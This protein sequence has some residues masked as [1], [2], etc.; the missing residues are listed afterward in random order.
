MRKIARG[1]TNR[2]S[3]VLFTKGRR[4]FPVA[5]KSSNT[6]WTPEPSSETTSEIVR[7]DSLACK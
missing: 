3:S 6:E 1:P 2:Y 5:E 4:L 7:T